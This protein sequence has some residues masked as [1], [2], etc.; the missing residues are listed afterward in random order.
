LREAVPKLGFEVYDETGDKLVAH[1]ALNGDPLELKPG[2]YQVHLSGIKLEPV[3][4]ELATGQELN[5][6]LDEDGK[7]VVPAG[8]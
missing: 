5:L 6:Q 1:G 4:I 7:L 3:A 8:P 2:K